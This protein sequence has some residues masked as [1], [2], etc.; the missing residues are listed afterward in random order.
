MCLPS[1]KTLLDLLLW[2]RLWLWLYL[3]S[4]LF[5]PVTMKGDEMEMTKEEL[6]KWIK[7][8]VK[9][10]KLIVAEVEKC[11]LLRSLLKKR[12]NQA[13]HLRQLRR[14]GLDLLCALVLWLGL[15][16]HHFLC[17]CALWTTSPA[18]KVFCAL[19]VVSIELPAGGNYVFIFY[20]G[21]SCNHGPFN[22][23]NFPNRFLEHSKRFNSLFWALPQLETCC[24]HLNEHILWKYKDE[25]VT[26]SPFFL[27]NQA[28]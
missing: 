19:A 7:K 25:H 15:Q 13:I 26:H 2:L 11:N 21:I 23:W 6:Q 1:S 27:Y 28:V 8:K 17:V 24:W 18:I 12:E 9:K 20:C 3:N 14:W 10:N 22:P 5:V 16:S 4:K